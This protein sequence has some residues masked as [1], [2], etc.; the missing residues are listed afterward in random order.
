MGKFLTK[1]RLFLQY[2]L[3]HL[4]PLNKVTNCFI[5]SKEGN[6]LSYLLVGNTLEIF[7]FWEEMKGQEVVSEPSPKNI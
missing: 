6:A 2:V 3:Q 5:A 4:Q 7:I 1:C